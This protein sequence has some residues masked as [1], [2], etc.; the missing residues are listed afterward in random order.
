MTFGELKVIKI[1]K[2][3]SSGKHIIWECLCSCG[4]T[5]YLNSSVLKSGHTKSCGHLASEVASKVHKKYNEFKFEESICYGKISDNIYFLIDKED[6]DLIK[7]YKWG[8]DDGYISSHDFENNHRKIRLHRII[9][10]APAGSIVDHINR[11][12]L[13]NRKENL[14]FVTKEENSRNISLSKLNKT[15][16]IGVHESENNTWRVSIQNKIYGKRYKDFEE[17]VAKRLSLE[18]EVFGKEFSPQR[19]LFKEYGIE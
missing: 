14:R 18:M 10:N 9:L 16:I 11:N 5:T 17:A 13:D 8:M 12:K 4:K 19:H 6:Y 1:H 3:G 7:K 15:G 2:K